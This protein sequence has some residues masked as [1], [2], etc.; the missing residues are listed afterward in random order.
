M[1]QSKFN[2]KTWVITW[3]VIGAVG[4]V[5]PVVMVLD[6]SFDKGSV[7]REERVDES[8]DNIDQLKNQIS[9]YY[10]KLDMDNS[11]V[12]VKSLQSEPSSAFDVSNNLSD[13][14]SLETI[15]VKLSKHIPELSE[16]LIKSGYKAV[17]VKEPN[18]DANLTGTLKLHLVIQKVDDGK[19]ESF[20]PD[21]SISSDLTKVGKIIS[22]T[23]F[24][25]L[26]P[27][28]VPPQPQPQPPVPQPAPATFNLLTPMSPIGTD[29]QSQFYRW[30]IQFPGVTTKQMAIWYL[31]AVVSNNKKDDFV[32]QII[33]LFNNDASFRTDVFIVTFNPEDIANVASAQNGY[34]STGDTLV[35]GGHSPT[36]TTGAPTG[37]NN[38]MNTSSKINGL[39]GLRKEL[40]NLLSLSSFQKPDINNPYT[41]PSAIAV[42]QANNTGK[43]IGALVPNMKTQLIHLTNGE[44]NGI[45]VDNT[46]LS[47]LSFS[48]DTNGSSLPVSSKFIK[49][50]DLYRA[51]PSPHYY[52]W[53]DD[54]GYYKG[55]AFKLEFDINGVYVTFDKALAISKS[56]ITLDQLKTSDFSG[57][58]FI[59]QELSDQRAFLKTYGYGLANLVWTYK[60]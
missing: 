58:N 32:N 54:D 31:Q 55:I 2:L 20:T 50:L 14:T 21:G 38:G 57:P 33:N 22:L 16:S 49:N 10:K 4:L 44:Y 43:I 26:T 17:L 9:E 27:Q 12:V 41:N 45:T 8:I 30:R 39:V 23:G 35:A 34:S 13:G 29:L 59:A 47:K 3:S 53:V 6:S 11:F 7:L 36:G 15:N 40:N 48:A 18:T 52:M 5:V 42:G 56:K 51:N 37:D 19:L 46:F 25:T 28:P 24:S 1:K 60:P